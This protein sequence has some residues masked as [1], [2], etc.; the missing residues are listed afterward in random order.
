M[1]SLRIGLVIDRL[2]PEK[3]GA[4]AYLLGLARYLVGQGHAVHHLARHFGPGVDAGSMQ[5]VPVPP[6]PRA[7]RDVAF[8]RAAARL[9]TRLGL[10][11]TL[12]V[13]HTPSTHVFQPHGGVYSRAAAAQSCSAGRSRWLHGLGR[14]GNPKHH[15]LMY[16]ERVQR[17]QESVAY[18]A[19]SGRVRADMVQAY[20]LEGGEEPEVIFNGVD[21]ERFR[22][23]AGH[24]DRARIRRTHNI[25]DEA[26]LVLFVAHNFRLKGLGPLLESLAG[27]DRARLLVVGRGRAGI[28]RGLAR[29]LGLENRVRFADS[30]RCPEPYYRAADVLAHP[31][32]YDPC[33]IVCLEA[34]ASGLPVITTRANGVG[35]LIEAE[36]GGRVLEEATDVAGLREVL[37]MLMEDATLRQRL[38]VE[39]RR[40]GESHPEDKAF[41]AM[42]RVLVSAARNRA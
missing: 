25:E 13:R 17:R 22:P 41:A 15:G 19:L 11:V 16:L 24:E 21:P 23:E 33:S 36:G 40:L 14:W 27:L 12:G 32:W 3:G 29:S 34:L 2:D 26:F 9:S 35:E 37:I 28:Y 6:L 30:T 8:D 20:G 39:A 42:E 7:L 5:P 31:T 18:V 10:E 38:A 1:C 4:E